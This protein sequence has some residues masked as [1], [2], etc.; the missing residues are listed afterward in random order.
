MDEGNES[1]Y[2]WSTL[3]KICWVLL[4]KFLLISSK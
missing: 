3:Y 2:N 1:E 4:K